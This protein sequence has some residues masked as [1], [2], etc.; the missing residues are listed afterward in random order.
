MR[1]IFENHLHRTP[2]CPFGATKEALVQLGEF[3]SAWVRPPGVNV[4][5][6]KRGEIR[7]AL[8]QVRL[9]EE[10]KGGSSRRAVAV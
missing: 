6:T 2:T 1:A 8:L 3:P 10:R 9:L 4:D 5:Q 7:T